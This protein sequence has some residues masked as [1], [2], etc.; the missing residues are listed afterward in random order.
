MKTFQF[1]FKNDKY[2]NPFFLI[3]CLNA[4]L[5]AT[6]ETLNPIRL[7]KET[8]KLMELRIFSPIY[9]LLQGKQVI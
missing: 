7:K 4:V 3:A 8:N 9:D 6:G 1:P 5:F 2:G